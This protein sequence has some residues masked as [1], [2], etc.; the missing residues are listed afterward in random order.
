MSLFLTVFSKG[1]FP[2][3]SKG[4]IVWEWDSFSWNHIS[5]ITNVP[6]IKATINSSLKLE[7]SKEWYFR[8]L[9]KAR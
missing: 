1:L 8:K 5:E 2:R 7:E 6:I 3:A 9:M 4:V